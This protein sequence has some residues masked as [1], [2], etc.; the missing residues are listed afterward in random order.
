MGITY[1]DPEL[2]RMRT[3]HGEID[4]SVKFDPEGMAQVAF[5]SD[6]GWL[7]ARNTVG[8]DDSVTLAEWIAARNELRSHYATAAEQGLKVMYE[9]INRL[10]KIG[11]AAT[12]RAGLSPRIPTVADFLKWETEVFG[13]WNVVA[14]EEVPP[15]LQEGPL[16][17]DPLHLGVVVNKPELF[18]KDKMEQAAEETRGAEDDEDAD[19]VEAVS[20][21]SKYDEEY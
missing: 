19:T 16:P 2:Q 21:F 14:S 10:R 13:S 7:V 8:L 18:S 6:K 20:N 11:E 9:A 17:D 3:K 5:E 1:D 15:L 12:I 4:I